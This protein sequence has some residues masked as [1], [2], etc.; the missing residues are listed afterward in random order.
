MILYYILLSFSFPTIE[1]FISR[2]SPALAKGFNALST[3]A[4]RSASTY[5]F[6]W[7]IGTNFQLGHEKFDTEDSYTSGSI[8]RQKLPRRLVNS[9]R[10]EKMSFGEG[11]GIAMTSGAKL[12]A[13]GKDYPGSSTLGDMRTPTLVNTSFDVADVACGSAHCGAVDSNGHVYLW[14]DNGSRLAGGGQLGNSSYTPSATPVLVESLAKAGVKVKAVSCGEKNTIFLADDGTV[15]SCGAA[16]YGRLGHWQ[17]W[18]ADMLEPQ[19]LTEVFGG[20]RIIQVAAGFSHSLALTESGKV[21]SWGRN[22]Q[23]QVLQPF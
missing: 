3:S 4:I 18:N 1:M 11:Y 19:Q 6:N 16:E 14:G 20:E 13:W 9:G 7:G 10:I 12:L 15:Y 23:G 5:I 17:N 22:D 8:Y 2:P 21:Y